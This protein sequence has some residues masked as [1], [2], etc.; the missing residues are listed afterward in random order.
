VF[1][2]AKSSD[3]AGEGHEFGRADG[4]EIGGVRKQDQPLAAII[5]QRLAAMGRQ[6]VE[7]GRGLV[8]AGQ[9][10]GLGG[11]DGVHLWHSSVSVGYPRCSDGRVILEIDLQ[12]SGDRLYR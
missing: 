5:G 3:A 6:R 8:Q 1:I 12:D 11:G 2:A 7:L 4:R 10:R 9:G